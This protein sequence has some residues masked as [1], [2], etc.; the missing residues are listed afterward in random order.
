MTDR[1]VYF[2]QLEYS[3]TQLGSYFNSMGTSVFATLT[4]PNS[5]KVYLY[6]AACAV[7]LTSSP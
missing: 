5:S 1:D 2:G 7:S 6:K 3:A 4:K